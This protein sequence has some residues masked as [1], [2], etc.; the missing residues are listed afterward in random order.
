MECE[1]KTLWIKTNV[2][3][4]VLKESNGEAL[5]DA[6]IIMKKLMIKQDLARSTF[7]ATSVIPVPIETLVTLV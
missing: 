4:F 1:K 6:T 7:F 5:Q 2:I 3:Y